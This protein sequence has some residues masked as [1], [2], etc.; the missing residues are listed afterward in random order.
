[1][2]LVLCVLVCVVW[3]IFLKKLTDPVVRWISAA[4][5]LRRYSQYFLDRGVTL[6][7][8]EAKALNKLV[9]DLPA[10]L[11]VRIAPY[12]KLCQKDLF[13]KR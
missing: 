3:V 7:V 4:L 10:W 8:Q 6:S 9:R 12:Q 2:V 1:L 11:Q 13:P 5:A